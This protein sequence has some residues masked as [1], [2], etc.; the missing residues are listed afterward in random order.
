MSNN[1]RFYF[2]AASL[3]MQDIFIGMPS[4]KN[5]CHHLFNSKYG[6]QIGEARCSGAAFSFDGLPQD[7]DESLR[8]AVVR[9]TMQTFHKV[10]LQEGVY[11]GEGWEA[12]ITD[13]VNGD[14]QSMIQLQATTPV[15]PEA[16]LQIHEKLATGQMLPA[17]N[18]NG[19]DLSSKGVENLV[20]DLGA[21][22]LVHWQHIVQ[23]A[24]D[25]LTKAGALVA[26]LTARNTELEAMLAQH[27]LV[28]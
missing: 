9:M 21:V 13:W 26:A 18:L 12:E 11:R 20:I 15:T 25:N 28:S 2:T 8:K 24:Q 22:D 27:T 5:G 4:E 10:K 6:Q 17:Y 19:Q 3:K 16:L 1:I 14:K 7:L 23:S